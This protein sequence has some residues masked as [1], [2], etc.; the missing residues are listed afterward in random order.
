LGLREEVQKLIDADRARTEACLRQA[1][2]FHQQQVERMR[3]LTAALREIVDAIPGGHVVLEEIA[4]LCK[5]CVLRDP[6]KRFDAELKIDV[7]PDWGPITLEARPGW[8][9]KETAI[10]EMPEYEVVERD[11]KLASGGDVCSFILPRL[12]QKVANWV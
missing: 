11:Q 7:E 10:Y 1:K 4:A 3:P 5:I 12:V 8:R 2:E 6:A 9:V